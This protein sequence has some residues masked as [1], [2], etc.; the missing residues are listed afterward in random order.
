MAAGKGDYGLFNRL[1]AGWAA[2]GAAE[3]AVLTQADLAVPGR[4]TL[5]LWPFDRQATQGVC[6]L[7]FDSFCCPSEMP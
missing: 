5:V 4:Q 7:H 2:G 6:A 1:M 3:R